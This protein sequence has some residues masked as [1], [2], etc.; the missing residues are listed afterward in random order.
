MT[1][2][3]SKTIPHPKPHLFFGN[4]PDLAIAA[5]PFESLMRLARENGPI[6]QLHFP[7]SVL[8]VVSSQE[9]VNEVCDESRFDK[10]VQGAVLQERDNAGDGLFTAYTQEPNWGLAHRILTPAF[11][12]MA[13]RGMFASMWDIAEQMLVKWERLRPE[14]RIDVTDNMSRLTLDTIGLCAFS[15]RFNS[16]YSE[17]LHP[18]V[19]AMARELRVAGERALQP[20][21]LTRLQL[22][23][24]WQHAEDIRFLHHVGRE[25]IA[26]RKNHP[27]PES[28]ND[29][30]SLMLTAKDH[31]TGQGL[32]E[33]NINNQMVT[34]LTAGHETTSG[35]LSFALYELLANPATLEKARAE[36][37]AVLGTETPQFEHLARLIYVDQVLKETLRLWPPAPGFSLYPYEPETMIGGGYPVRNDQVIFVLL[38]ML[39]RDPKVWEEPDQFEPSRM[40]PEKFAKLPPNAWK[41]FGNGRRACIGR[42]FA[43]QEATL[44]L[45]SILQRFDI[46]KADP[47]YRLKIKQTL[48]IK[49][50]GFFIKVKRRAVRIAAPKE[51][52]TTPATKPAGAEAALGIPLRVLFGSNSG[53]S[54]AFAQRIAT[55]A[56]QQGYAATIGTLDS[57]VGHLSREGAVVVV[58]ASYEGEPADNA[59]Q[60]VLWLDTLDAGALRGIRYAVFG[61]GNKDW[62]H[63]YQ[64]IPKRIDEKMSAAGAQRLIER[65]A[66]DARGDFFGDFDRWYAPFWKTLGAMLGQEV[67]QVAA[68]PPLQLEFVEGARDPLLRLNNLARGA[69][70][71]NHELVDVTSPLAR[72][73][74]H[75]EIELPAGAQYRAGDYL[76]VLPSNPTETVAR[77]LRRFGLGYDAQVV[78]HSTS[79]AQTFFPTGSPVLAGELLACYVELAQPATRQQIQKLLVSTT[80]VSEKEA[81][82]TWAASDESYTKEILAKRVSI[83]DLLERTKSCNLP[84]ATFLQVLPP[85]LPRQYSISSSPRWSATHCTITVAVLEAPAWSGHGTYRGVASTY[86]ARARPGM[87]IAVMTRPSQA[88]FHLPDSL[89]TP[90]IMVGAGTGIAPFRGFIQ[91]RVFRAAEEGLAPGPALLFF[92]CDHPDVDFLYRDELKLWEREG[93]VQVR[94]AF[95]KA[96]DGDIQF[97]QHR[98]WKDRAEVMALIEKGARIYVCGDGKYMAPAVRETFGRMYQACSDCAPD[99]VEAW[100]ADLEKSIRY[101]QDVFA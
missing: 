93:A 51:P 82:V 29:L 21:L 61:C 97:V 15:Y 38:P 12:P 35:L 69:V 26:A 91:E 14:E 2:A 48:T 86:L 30:L 42:P 33:D 18:Y 40:A 55:D 52:S 37:D 45:A 5:T 47:G 79:G 44:A 77:A 67:K 84:F 46:A 19:R 64:A 99:R 24:A 50:D 4:V 73:K 56:M 96:A 78:L 95:L 28:F 39:H 53:S 7:R 81:L 1:V 87:K 57:A 85:M 23:K 22:F 54:E 3:A 20:A 65:G 71:D 9:L 10:K 100:L 16:F 34:F 92:G 43:L 6:F 58:T 70:V 11:S 74:R 89:A 49:P 63:T 83:L 101:S 94:P 8:I 31:Q 27:H 66:A 41:P 90:I 59:K 60:F 88:A 13:L 76:S 68:V 36:V 75:I 17:E 72:S 98:L 32:S 80:D 62:A 25:V